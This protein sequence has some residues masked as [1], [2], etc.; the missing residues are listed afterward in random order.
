MPPL[1]L[2]PHV[3]PPWCKLVPE[4]EHG[5][6]QGQA[7]GLEEQRELLQAPMLEVVLGCEALVHDAH[8]QREV[9]AGHQGRQLAGCD[10]TH[11]QGAA[12]G[13]VEAPA[14]VGGG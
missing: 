6:L 5:L 2:R 3:A 1:L 11:W 8:A 14:G 10:L 7:D 13:L 9:A 12:R 4:E